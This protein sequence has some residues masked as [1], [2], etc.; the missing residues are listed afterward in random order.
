[1]QDSP[2]SLEHAGVDRLGQL[3][4]LLGSR[5]PQPVDVVVETRLG[6]RLVITGL[7]AVN[8][9]RADLGHGVREQSD[10]DREQAVERGLRAVRSLG[11]DPQ[12][13][14]EKPGLVRSEDGRA[15][16]ALDET[17]R[18]TGR[19]RQLAARPRA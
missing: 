16:L 8:C 10:L 5:E 15:E 7:Q 14:I 2:F 18:A 17:S 9:A 19:R 12:R 3:P 6:D 11:R 1:M 4:E 13:V